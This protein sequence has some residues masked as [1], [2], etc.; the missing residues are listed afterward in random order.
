MKKVVI[1]IPGMW[2]S[3]REFMKSLAKSNSGY[4][5]T[6]RVMSNLND[7]N[8][9]FSIDMRGATPSLIEA[10]RAGGGRLFSEQTLQAMKLHQSIIY[11]MSECASYTEVAH[12]LKAVNAVLRS[13]GLAV[14]VESTGRAMTKEGWSQ[15]ARS[16]KAEALFLCFVQMHRSKGYYYTTGMHVFGLRDL[17]VEEKLSPQEASTLFRSFASYVLEEQPDLHDGHSFSIQR[18][19]PIYKLREQA[20]VIDEVDHPYGWWTFYPTAN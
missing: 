15:A 8:E 18:D 14:Y 2:G 7:S 10:L 5:A 1:A 4:I 13:G 16:S 20:A 3:R 12:L 9:S 17:A 19:A 11:V 6:E